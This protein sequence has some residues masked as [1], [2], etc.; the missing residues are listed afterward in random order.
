MERQ[1]ANLIVVSG[2]MV[3]HATKAEF[4]KARE[5]LARLPTSPLVTP[6]NHD[7]PFYN[8]LQRMLT[9]LKTYRRYI[10]D[11]PAPVYRDDELL[12]LTITTPRIFPMKGGR[13]SAEQVLQTRRVACAAPHGVIRV[14]VTH[15]PLD[16]PEQYRRSTLA[17]HARASVMALAPCIDLMIAG[18]LHL[19]S[20]GST[21]AR[22]GSAERT[23]VFAQAGTAIS[24]RNKGE[25]NSFNVIRTG[26]DW[27]EIEHHVWNEPRGAFEPGRCERFERGP[28]GWEKKKDSAK[29]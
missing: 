27:V 28:R 9:G 6:G 16:V 10:S 14:L 19:S 23:L 7:L 2:D 4:E 13:I 1:R 25:P 29:P 20:T 11:D 26:A 21:A 17:H 3:E 24:K 22:Y 18:H 12:V 5:F 15:H 8:P